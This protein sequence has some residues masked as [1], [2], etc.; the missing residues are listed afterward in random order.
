MEKSSRIVGFLPGSLQLRGLPASQ[1]KHQV[2][3][4]E[5]LREVGRRENHLGSP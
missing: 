1:F 3:G 4:P 2:M 5:S